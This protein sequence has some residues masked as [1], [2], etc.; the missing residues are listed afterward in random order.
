MPYSI[1]NGIRIYYEVSGDGFPFV[2]VHANPFDH[3]LWMYQ[4]SHFS[5]YFRVIAMD[6]RG[7]GRSDKPASAFSL[8]DMAEDV[9]GVCRDENVKEAVLGGVSVGSG[10][11][12]L[13]GLDHP[14]I[15]KALILVGGNSGGGGRI[16]DRIYGYTKTGLEKYHRQ[17]LEE[18]VS[19][20][21]SK[22]KLGS[23]VLQTFTE[24]D[25]WLSGEVIAQIFRARADTDLTHRLGDMKVPSLI[26]N[27]EYDNS[28]PAGKKT[29]ALI[30]GAVHKILPKTGHAC[31]IEDPAG[32]DALVAD[33]LSTHGYMPPA[34]N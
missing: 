24:R 14:E 6:I 21:F 4:I 10:I 34:G 8:K 12:L 16:E 26:I 28:L 33:F 19:P 23:Y 17:H 3:N 27:G 5:T 29:A 18:L 30:P 9:L 15:F 7:Y 25:P 22:T 11:A 2:M 13:L 1:A 20:E 31:C 32:F